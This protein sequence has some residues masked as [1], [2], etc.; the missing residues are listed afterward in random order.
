MYLTDPDREEEQLS[1]DP[2]D[3]Q[4]Y[5][6]LVKQQH[7]DDHE[8]EQP[9]IGFT[10]Q[11]YEEA[12][13]FENEESLKQAAQSFENRS[14]KEASER[15]SQKS[16]SEKQS[17]PRNVSAVDIDSLPIRGAQNI[18]KLPEEQQEEQ[19]HDMETCPNCSRTFLPGRLAMHFKICRPD[20]PMIKK[21]V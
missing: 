11:M 4:K 8:S 6:E 2:I 14:K 5:I 12:A 21:V 16:R 1:E 15:E 9:E 13:S 17:A 10:I 7:T 19:P 18:Q 3:N 20:K